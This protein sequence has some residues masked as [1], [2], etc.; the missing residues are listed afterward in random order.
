MRLGDAIRFRSITIID[1]PQG[2]GHRHSEF[3]FS[4]RK[5]GRHFLAVFLGHVPKEAAVST[6]DLH[7]RLNAVNL[8]HLDQLEDATEDL[9]PET[10]DKVFA[11]LGYARENT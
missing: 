1:E 10:R 11:R 3:G 7:A 6:E 9:D 4:G 5:Q 2:P 8:V